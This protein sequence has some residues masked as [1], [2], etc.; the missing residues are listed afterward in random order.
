M[1]VLPTGIGPVTGGYQIERSLRFNSADSAY[2]NRTPASAGN[3]DTWTYSA[4]IKRSILST[5]QTFF[6]ARSDGSNYDYCSFNTS[7]QFSWA[8]VSGGS[9]VGRLITTQVFRD[10]SSWY[11]F[12]ITY[13]SGN[14][15]GGNRMRFYVNG[16]E[17]TAF[18]TDTNP[19]QNQ[20]GNINNT[21]AHNI[22]RFGDGT[23]YCNYYQTET[24]F[25]DGQA[26]TP[27]SFGETDSN[28]GVWK[29]KAYTGTYGTN[30][31]YL[32]F[33]DN[34]STTTL[35]YDDAGS[36]DWTTNNFSVTAGAGNDS[37]VDSPTSYGTDTGVGGEVRG[38]YAT[39]NPL[40]SSS[41]YALSNGNLKLVCPS[42]TFPDDFAHATIQ[43][44]TTGKWYWTCRY[45]EAGGGGGVGVTPGS[46]QVSYGTLTGTY[47][48]FRADGTYAK[49]AGVT[50]N[51]TPA[52]ASDGDVYTFAFDADNGRLYIAK[53]A[54]PNTSSTAQ[55]TGFTTGI[56]YNVSFN[57]T[58]N[59]SQQT[60]EFCFGASAFPY[61]APSGFKALCTQNLPT[62]TIGATSTTQAGKYFNPILWTATDAAS[63]ALTGVGFQPDFLWA[64]SRNTAGVSHRLYD[65]VRGATTGSLVTDSTAAEDTT[66]GQLTSFNTDGFTTGTNKDYLNFGSRTYVGWCWKANG[67]GSSNTAGSITSTVS[68]N[69]TSGFS[70]VTWTGQSS[71]TA[72]IGHGLGVVPDMVI[73]KIR[74]GSSS[75]WEVYHKNLTSAAYTIRLQS[76][77]AQASAANVWNSTAPTSTVFS[78]GSTYA[79]G[80]AGYGMVAYCF[81]PVAGYSAFGSYVGN[82]SADGPFV[83][84]GFRPAYIMVKRF[85]ST[86]IWEIIDAKRDPY[87]AAD[88]S[89]RANASDAEATGVG[90]IDFLSNGFKL[91][92]T[93]GNTNDS[94]TYLYA[95]FAENP[96]KYSLAR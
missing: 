76:T 29:P 26:L 80:G 47:A 2:L 70:I 13:D 16:T 59:T 28:T 86:G 67:A 77:A 35:G 27:S 81:A 4:W 62:P 72:T 19:S 30:G 10:V 71:G 49:A 33:K 63:R 21:I 89:L 41:S 48:T 36:N 32:S 85:T 82:S 8:I 7:D 38:N 93:G 52:S 11:H 45:T 84:L 58:T 14:A 96:F 79:S 25:I 74:S 9:T 90:P 43:I 50:A 87:N 57:N 44:P 12:L 40:N 15:T 92:G 37:L 22:G 20:D 78:V 24:Y 23:E 95:A 31:F 39:M 17:V 91:R 68:A 60:R 18:G 73:M 54:T 55:L 64:K 75:D 1:A 53:N 5:N 6:S 65:A 61:A 56:P 69:T 83:Y 46:V 3:R 42:G 51:S 66:A 88:K 34:T 94:G